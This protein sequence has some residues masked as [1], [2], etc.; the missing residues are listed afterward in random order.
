MKLKGKRLK[1][2]LEMDGGLKM[3]ARALEL[4]LN[5]KRRKR[6]QQL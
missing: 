4:K 3:E 5:R 6:E 1:K 2:R